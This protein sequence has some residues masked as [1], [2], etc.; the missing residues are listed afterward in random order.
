MTT[1]SA[2]G[3]R[4]SSRPSVAVKVIPSLIHARRQRCAK[5][6]SAVKPLVARDDRAGREER[7]DLRAEP[8]GE[9]VVAVVVA[10]ADVGMEKRDLAGETFLRAAG[11]VSSSV[12][13]ISRSGDGVE[14]G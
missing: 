12:P 4:V 5:C 8:G 7:N 14:A 10:G 11:S 6:A 1:P 2:D 13:T 9:A 3:S